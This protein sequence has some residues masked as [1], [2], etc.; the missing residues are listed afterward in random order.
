MVSHDCA[1]EKSEI[2]ACADPAILCTTRIR[3]ADTLE[4]I[5]RGQALSYWQRRAG[6]RVNLIWRLGI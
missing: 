3:Q 2:T 6:R 1:R 4:V 5:E